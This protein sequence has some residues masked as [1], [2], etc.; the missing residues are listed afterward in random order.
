MNNYGKNKVRIMKNKL[1]L[2][3]R[4]D[5]IEMYVGN[6]YQATYFFEK[7]MGFKIVAHKESHSKKDDIKSLILNQGDIYII[8]TSALNPL[9]P[10]SKF[11]SMHGDCIKDVAFEISNIDVLFQK[12]CDKGAN[13]LS[14][15]RTFDT[16]YGKIKKASIKV[17]GDMQHSLIERE[18]AK[19]FYLPGYKFLHD[20]NST[21]NQLQ[22]IDH[23]AIALEEDTLETWRNFYQDM[24]SLT[25]QSTVDIATKYSGMRSAVLE[26]F[27]AKL[28]LL[29]AKNGSKQSQIKSF[30]DY[31]RG[32][33]IQHIALST[34]EICN[35][36]SNMSKSGINFLHAPSLY[37]KNIKNSGK[38][39]PQNFSEFSDLNILI[40]N[41]EDGY[42]FQIFTKPIHHR[43]TLFFEIIQ[44]DGVKGFGEGNINAL[45]EAIEKAEL[46]K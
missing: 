35:V 16:K 31:N 32:P 40:E 2:I 33:G 41:Q 10:I 29:E 15:L 36:V 26:S 25:L 27:E 45:F 6:L 4:I 14:S 46:E 34:T 8:L 12:A 5:H 11:V 21:N 30:L 38:K 24:L 3:K 18:G 20:K 13:P 43:N 9:N 44:R 28:V 17:F 37:Y 19:E 23:I 7:S 1:S 39:L 22:S 42:L